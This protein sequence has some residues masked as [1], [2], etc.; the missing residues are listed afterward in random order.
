M[1][2]IKSTVLV[3]CAILGQISLASPDT[4]CG[5]TNAT[6][7][8]IDLSTGTDASSYSI[9]YLA[10]PPSGGF[11]VDSYKTGKLVLRRIEP[12]S[13]M[14]H[15]EFEITLT[16]PYYIGVFEV[17]QT[18]YSLVIGNQSDNAGDKRPA[19]NVSYDT[20]R[21]SNLGAKWPFSS[22]V[23][24]SSFLGKLRARSGLEFDLPTEAQ[25]EYACRA[26]TT[27]SFNNNGNTVGDLEQVGRYEGNKR[28]GKGGFS[29]STTVG[30][31]LPNAWGLY[32]MHGNV[33]EWCLDRE[34][35][36]PSR[37]ETDPKGYFREEQSSDFNRLLR[38]GSWDDPAECCTSYM[39][40]FA[41]PRAATSSIGFRLVL[42]LSNCQ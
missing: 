28:D 25:W 35:W 36:T 8:V 34:G 30:S 22:A 39:R 5:T 7:C 17:T 29:R 41:A 37:P 6:Y 13:F 27:S 20:I 33:S 40:D 19:V 38:G 12:G 31:Y 2:S 3:A 16:K 14:W 15:G 32:D 26:G 21:G 1:N 42:T 18:Q 23:D 11:N 9:T 4:S 24:S 10:E